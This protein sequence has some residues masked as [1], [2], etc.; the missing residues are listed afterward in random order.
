[1][2][3]SQAWEYGHS[4]LYDSPTPKLDARLLLEHVLQVG[5]SQLI[6]HGQQPLTRVQEEQLRSLLSRAQQKE[7]IPHLIGRAP[8]GELDL[9]VSPDVLIPR[10]E[11]ELLVQA[12][13]DWAVT[14]QPLKLVD[15]GTGSGCIAIMLA[16]HLTAS[17]V[18]AV[19]VSAPA[20]AIARQN[21][22]RYVPGRIR[23]YQGHLLDPLGH[24]PDLI[25]A[26]LPYVSDG[27]WTRLDDGVKLYEPA[28]AL[29]GG[30]DGLDLIRQLLKQAATKLSASGAVF[31]EIGWKQGPAVLQLAQSHFPTARIELM[32][33]YAGHDRI[34]S[35]I[36]GQAAA[37]QRG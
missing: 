5:H 4:Q 20:L 3:I 9:I 24:R 2:N 11:T 35:I 27:E 19:D 37:S 16:L 33:D 22:R 15:V 30:D 18:E 10:P 14:R 1:M 32:P 36:L 23:F 34:V 17:T 21:A 25:V 29:R 6:A 8:F 26:N 13:L 31:L 7:P 28:V 12:V